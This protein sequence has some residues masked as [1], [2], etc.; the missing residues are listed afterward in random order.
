[1]LELH[2]V[3]TWHGNIHALRGASLAARA[4]ELLAVVGANGAGKSTLLGT[5]AGLYRPRRGRILLG[6]RE[7]TGRPVEEAVRLGVALVPERRQ[8]FAQLTVRENLL[9]GAYHH[10][11]RVRRHLAAEL[12]RVFQI[13][14]VLAQRQGQVAGTLSGGEQQM[15]AIGRGLMSRP[16]LLLLDEPSL[17]LAP[18]VVR[19]IFRVLAE[20]KRSG[21]M[22]VVL[23]EQNARAAFRVADRACVVERGQVVLAGTP[24]DLVAD[25]R[26]QA[27]YLGLGYGAGALA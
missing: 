17:G 14:P 18:R 7:I 22:T 23:V 8:I 21:E 27:A 11:A 13:F 12:E 25:P 1:M 26:I 16:R 24:T 2:G 15:L 10:Y 19:E 3:H 9:L 4:G 6:G 20:L 5:V